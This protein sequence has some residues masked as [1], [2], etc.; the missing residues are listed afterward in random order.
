M[1]SYVYLGYGVTDSNG[2]AKLD[3]NASGTSIDH[4]Y[5]GTGAGE[6][7]VVASLDSTI[8][9]SSIVS[10]NYEVLDALYYDKALS[11]TGNYNDSMWKKTSCTL[12]RDTDGSTMQTSANYGSIQVG[13]TS[14]AQ[15]VPLPCVVELEVSEMDSGV[16][17]E[18][19]SWEQQS[20]SYKYFNPNDATG[21]HRWEI[22]SDSQKQFVDGTQVKTDNKTLGNGV[23]INISADNSGDKIKF[24]EFKVYPL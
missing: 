17:F 4:S 10:N 15:S 7:D 19:R 14:S 6:I 13:T 23:R 12:T 8:T 16:F 20:G 2:I 9:G 3:H 11:G 24:K 1:V 22:R 18:V 5:T 21:V